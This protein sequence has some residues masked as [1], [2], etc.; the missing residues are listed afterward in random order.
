LVSVEMGFAMLL[1]DA[2][3][4]AEMFEKR[5]QRERKDREENRGVGCREQRQN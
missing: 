3:S 5:R 2:M 4:A 1:D